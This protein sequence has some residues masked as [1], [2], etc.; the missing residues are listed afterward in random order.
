M[1]TFT[2]TVEANIIMITFVFCVDQ[3]R[4]Q[5]GDWGGRPP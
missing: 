2:L 1:L 3:R 5:G 4:I